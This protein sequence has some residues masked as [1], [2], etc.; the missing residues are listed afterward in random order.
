MYDN[1][2]TLANTRTTNEQYCGLNIFQKKH[3]HFKFQPLHFIYL[4]ILYTT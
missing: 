2:Q 4:V 3:T 1:A